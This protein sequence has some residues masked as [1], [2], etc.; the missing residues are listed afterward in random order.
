MTEGVDRPNI[1]VVTEPFAGRPLT[2]VMDWLLRA[3]PRVT[4]L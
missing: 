1:G 3:A 2:D 4:D